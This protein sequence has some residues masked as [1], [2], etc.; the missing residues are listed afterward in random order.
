MVFLVKN[1]VISSITSFLIGKYVFVSDLI[2]KYQKRKI[3]IFL[4]EKCL[5]YVCFKLLQNS[6]KQIRITRAKKLKMILNAGITY[7]LT[8]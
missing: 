3:L 8:I 2:V 5:E 6:Q 1:K 7:L 4:L